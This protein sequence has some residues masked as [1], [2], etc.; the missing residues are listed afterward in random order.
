MK[1]LSL[2]SGIGAFEKALD[3]IGIPYDLIGY[4][5]IDDYASKSYS[6]IHGLPES[7][8]YR[9]VTKIN[10]RALPK[11]IDLLTY[12]FP[13]QDI[14]VAGVQR[15]LF[16][17]DGTPTRSG[18]F[19]DALRIIQEARPCVAVAENVK[20]LTGAKFGEQFS[21][22]LN[23]LETAGYNSYWQV[24][25]AQDQNIP[26]NRERVFIVSVRKDV[27][28][29]CFT[30]PASQKL[31]TKLDDLLEDYVD[32]TYY[33]TEKFIEQ[34]KQTN[35][36]NTER[37]KET[38]NLL[39]RGKYQDLLIM[40]YR[41]DEGLRV[42][43]NNLCP[44]LTTRGRQSISGVPIINKEGRLRFITERECFRFMGFDDDDFDKVAHII[45]SNQLYK[46]A[47]NSIVVNVIE[48]ILKKLID[49]KILKYSTFDFLP[50]PNSF[51]V[52]E[53]M[54]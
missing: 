28:N 18:L 38:T 40:D 33:L 4:C 9:D 26:Q 29:G 10:E 20:A 53:W 13:C 36:R 49:T 8:N 16:N 17:E 48:A 41:Y 44:T 51:E 24:M 35:Y 42:R 23:S 46:Q 30:F 6:L 22:I 45:P 27:D 5:E 1:V 32:P 19:F 12:G 7:L 52:E 50:T 25:K 54:I 11:D 3:K 37:H 39:T 15:G 2:F 47:G 43:R 31:K 21:L 34:I 14:S